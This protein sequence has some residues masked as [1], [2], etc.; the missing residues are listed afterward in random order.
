MLSPAAAAALQETALAAKSAAVSAAALIVRTS[1]GRHHSLYIA[2]ACG[3][4]EGLDQAPGDG[5]YAGAGILYR[6]LQRS[7]QQR[8]R[9]H[10]GV[11]RS[12]HVS[13][14]AL[15]PGKPQTLSPKP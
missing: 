6:H 11:G 5:L 13:L 3:G 14:L 1:Q 2:S 9:L 12:R 10:D 4:S 15:T 7:V 8:P